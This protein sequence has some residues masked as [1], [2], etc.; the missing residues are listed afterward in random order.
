M[1]TDC[2][3]LIY[4]CCGHSPGQANVGN[5]GEA[6]AGVV[7]EAGVDIVGKAGVGIVGE[8]TFGP[9]IVAGT[10]TTRGSEGWVQTRSSE[11]EDSAS[12]CTDEGF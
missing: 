1:A 11:A 10:C 5:D 4:V 9:R 8:A 2:S 12:S 3:T 7:G 6:S